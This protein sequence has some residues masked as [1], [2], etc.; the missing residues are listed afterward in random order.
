MS[1]SLSMGAA[2]SPATVSKGGL[3]GA[4]GWLCVGTN[5]FVLSKEDA[6]CS[7]KACKKIKKFKRQLS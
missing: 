5:F 7:H 2:K 4:E 3:F 1:R 6:I